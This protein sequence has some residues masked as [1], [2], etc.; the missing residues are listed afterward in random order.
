MSTLW[1]NSTAAQMAYCDMIEELYHPLSYN[2]KRYYIAME[3]VFTK[4]NR[5]LNKRLGLQKINKSWEEKPKI[6]KQKEIHNIFNLQKRYKMEEGSQQTSPQPT[7]NP[8]VLLINSSAEEIGNYIVEKLKT[9]IGNYIHEQFDNAKK[10][11]DETFNKFYDRKE[12]CRILRISEPSLWK[13]SK[14]GKIPSF[15]IGRRIL[16]PKAEILKMINI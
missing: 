1:R 5:R 15:K 9:F 14:T 3:D 16:Y 2:E 13:L 8:A 12:V 10:E 6:K 7:S 4:E 11:E